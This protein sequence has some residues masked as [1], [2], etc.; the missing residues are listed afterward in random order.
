MTLDLETARTRLTE[1][2]Y[3]AQSKTVANPGGM[4]ADGHKE[5]LPDALQAVG[6][7]GTAAAASES[8]ATAD[9]ATATA[10]AGTATTQAGIAT[11]QA[12]IATTKAAEAAQSA[13]D[14]AGAVGGLKVSLDDGTP[15]SLE[16]KL[17]FGDG[18][19]AVTENPGAAELRRMRV[20]ADYSKRVRVWAAIWGS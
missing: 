6:L 10:A 15:G 8:T 18:L 17:V 2:Y 19:S 5:N 9:A 13:L 14:A 7:V 20:S 11:T 1:G 3:N 4:G 12:G 16:D